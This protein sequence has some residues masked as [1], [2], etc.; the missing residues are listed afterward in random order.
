MR[1]MLMLV[2][3]C[4][5]VSALA[6]PRV[7]MASSPAANNFGFSALPRPANNDDA[8]DATLTLV[9]GTR[10]GNSAPLN[11]L[12][13]GRIPR[14][15]DDP[16]ASFFFAPDTDGGRVLMDLGAP[17]RLTQINTYSWHNSDRSPQVYDL[18][19]SD[20]SAAKFAPSPKRP[21][22][23]QTCGW[24]LLARVDTRTKDA[25][26]GQQIASVTDTRGELG[27]YRYLLFDIRRTAPGKGPFD[28]TFFCEF[29]VMS[30]TS[31]APSHDETVLREQ[32]LREL[33]APEQ[34]MRFI[35]DFT[36]APNLEDWV[37]KDLLSV[38]KEW[39]PKLRVMLA[40]PGFTPA[41]LVTFRLR[42][43]MDGP[44]SA[45]G[46]NINLNAKWTSD[47]PK[48]ALGASVHEMVHIVQ[49]Y[50][51]GNTPGWLVEGIA[52]YIR[53]F[54]Y[55]PE[56]RGAEITARNIGSARYDGSYRVSANFLDW[57]I[58]TYG[59][60]GKFLLTLN[61][62]LRDGKYTDD[63]WKAK[64]GKTLSELNDLW[65]E[66]C[67]KRIAERK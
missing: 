34:S 29:D 37:A 23:P 14:S 62:T 43:D 54:L 60:D 4:G 45:G 39:Y 38:C 25:T 7:K 19:A 36:D 63:F 26:R 65:L 52:D 1:C 18:Y 5:A 40:A 9:D 50:S 27:N 17:R 11:V 53:W 57:V 49:A 46:G 59:R 20:G 31:P 56:S 22:D 12:T 6:E 67:R 13:N 30:K 61:A 44:A 66:D 28:N 33:N 16:R 10:D 3:C 42:T 41:S 48:E 15:D 2:C 35:A 8:A 64:T 51:K 32:R 58:R 47:V 21:Q 24:R 55:E